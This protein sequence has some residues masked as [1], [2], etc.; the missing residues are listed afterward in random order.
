MT[1]N[2]PTESTVASPAVS[3][4][5]IPVEARLWRAFFGFIHSKG[6]RD[7]KGDR[8]AQRRRYK[9]RHPEKI[10]AMA[11][12]RY[13][14]NSERIK[15]QVM[16]WKK[17]HPERVTEYRARWNKSPKG[18]RSRLLRNCRLTTNAPDDLVRACLTNQALKKEIRNERH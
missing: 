13:L 1:T 16:R 10:R 8:E 5:N 15:L 4:A 7:H 6:R 18:Q 14:R 11:R 12:A 2:H 17:A 3:A 9:E